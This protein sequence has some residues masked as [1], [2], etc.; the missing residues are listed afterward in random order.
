M[1]PC[2]RCGGAVFWETDMYSQH[3][4]CVNCGHY[5]DE[6]PRYNPRYASRAGSGRR[7]LP[8]RPKKE[9]VS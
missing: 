3:Q 9:R 4:R 5:Y 1:K 6:T 7:P 2:P 8:G